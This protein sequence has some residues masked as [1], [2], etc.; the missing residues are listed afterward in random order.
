[1]KGILFNTEMVMAILEGRKT[2][3]RRVVKPQPLDSPII[4]DDE[5]E[6]LNI[7]C[8]VTGRDRLYNFFPTYTRSDILYVRE[9]WCQ[10][11]NGQYWYRADNQCC[12]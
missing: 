1:M 4:F 12:G 10:T 9:T 6:G 8:H 5:V 11:P 7:V 2:E 3:T